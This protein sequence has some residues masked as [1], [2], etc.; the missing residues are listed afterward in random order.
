MNSKTSE[1]SNARVLTQLMT[2]I[3]G[4]MLA[5]DLL[6]HTLGYSSGAALRKAASRDTVPVQLME[7][8]HR[9]LKFALSDEVSHWLIMQ[10]E[11]HH[12][13]HMNLTE[14]YGVAP[15]DRLKLFVFEYGYL[16]NE[17]DILKLLGLESRQLLLE[18]VETKRLPFPMFRLNQRQT[19][20]FALSVEVFDKI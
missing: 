1:N 18:Q 8:P 20:L 19:R 13:A 10:R 4:P 11:S 9:K 3:N 12:E 14:S 2:L 17:D 16:L 5:G 7:F 6:A 15:P